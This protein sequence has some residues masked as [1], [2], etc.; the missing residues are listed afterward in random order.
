MF[1]W[2]I[3]EKNLLG[4]SAVDALS[5]KSVAV[6]GLGGVGSWAAEAIVR[7]GIGRVLLCDGDRVDG[8][9][10]NRQLFALHSTVGELKTELAARR[11]KDI[12]PDLSVVEKPVFYDAATCDGFDLSSFDYVVDCIDTVTSKLLLVKTC[13]SAYKP[14]ISC[15]GT[16]NKLDN[17]KFKIADIYETKVCPLAKVMRRE[18]KKQGVTSLKVVYSEEEPKVPCCEDK[19]TPASISFVPPVA[20]LMIAGEVIN[21]LL[22]EI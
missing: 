22:K 7:A 18:L 10:I 17:T 21:D 20:G 1:D 3:R 9:N 6:F 13:K 8:S 14:V 4:E 16:G 15:L 11:F 12:N 5:K 19:R 2:Q